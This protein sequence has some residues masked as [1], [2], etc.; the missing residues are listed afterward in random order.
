[1]VLLLKDRLRGLLNMLTLLRKHDWTSAGRQRA[2][3]GSDRLMYV[4]KFESTVECQCKQHEVN[5]RCFLQISDSKNYI[6]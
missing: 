3:Q 4:A 1:M 5:P 6:L 2:V